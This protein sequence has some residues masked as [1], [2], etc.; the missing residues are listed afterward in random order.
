MGQSGGAVPVGSVAF[1]ASRSGRTA[2]CTRGGGR[3]ATARAAVTL[4]PLV[5]PARLDY[6]FSMSRLARSV[7][8]GEP[9]HVIQRG[10]RRAAV[11]HADEER[12]AY[13]RL[14]AE[15]AALHGVRI[16]GYCLMTNHVHLIAVPLRAEALARALRGV[17]TVYAMQYNTRHSVSGHLWQ[18][19]FK[20]C[21]MDN[22]Y[23]WRA[24]RYVERNPVRAGMVERAEDYPWSSA[25]AHCGLRKDPLLDPA[26]PPQG[27][28]PDWADW[29]ASP[30]DEEHVQLIRA[31]TNTNRPCGSASFVR[32]AEALLGRALEPKA[33]GRKRKSISAGQGELFG[34]NNA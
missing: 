19:R 33:P 3:D 15:Y 16:W 34:E 2:D 27:A 11:F 23:L 28:I 14:L 20:S 7:V 24:L 30:E 10:N 32:R 6:C 1:G 31:R 17:H 18:G 25:V 22:E 13:L 4:R 21:P 26:F 29:L 8:P 12:R 5:F 9:H